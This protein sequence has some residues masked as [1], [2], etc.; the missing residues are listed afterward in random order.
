MF[1]QLLPDLILVTTMCLVVALALGFASIRFR[2]DIDEAVEQINELLPQTQCAQCGHPGCRPYAQSIASGEAINRCPPGGQRT[3]SELANLLARETLALD[4][5]FGKTEPPHIARIR[6]RECV[7]CTLCIQVCPVDSIFGAPQ[8]M[9]VILEQI[10]TGCDLCVPS[11]P[12]DCIELLELPQK[13][14]PIPA[15]SALSILACIRC[16]NCGRQCPQHLA[17][18]E[19]LWQSNSSSAMDLLSLNDCTECRLCDQLCPSKIPLTNFFS[20]LKKQLSQEDQDLIRAR[21][22]ELRFIRRNDR[23]DSSKSKLRTRATSADRAEII[24]QLRKSE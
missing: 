10:C 5:T 7:G 11:C 2:S 17:P 12:V 15:D 21:E 3:I 23:L 22:S 9:H 4:E 13:S 16:G 6:A 18:Q 8:Q 14:Q 1:P 24:A 20:A 19:L